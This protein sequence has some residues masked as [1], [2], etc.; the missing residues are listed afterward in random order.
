M[1]NDRVLG[2]TDSGLETWLVFHRG[3]DL[4]HFAA[5]PLL[6]DAEGRELLAEYVRDHVRVAAARS[7]PLVVETPTWRASAAWG[8]SLGYDAAA[9]DRVNRAA[10]AF[11]REVAAE[12]ADVTVVVSGNVGPQGDGYDP[13]E[14]LTANDAAA[15]HRAQIDSFVAAAADRVT[16]L[17]ATH[18]GEAAGVVLAADGRLPVV[19][20]FTVETDGRLPSGHALAEAIEEVDDQTGAAALYFGVNCA[21]PDHFAAVLDSGHPA[22][23]RIGLIRANASR[24]SHEEL[25]A[26]EKLD[27]GDPLELAAQYAELVRRHPHVQVVGGCCGTDSRHVAAIAEACLS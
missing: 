10:V 19:I 5:F 22:M 9:L 17:T 7:A 21:H 12:V 2:L 15:Y 18:P 24:A 14:L 1:P 25:D 16:M 20:S 26:M 13:A 11:T 3:V 8:A 6:D 4:S 23:Q 27:D